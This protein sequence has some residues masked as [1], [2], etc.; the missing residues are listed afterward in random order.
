MLQ[1]RRRVLHRRTHALHAR[2]TA[3]VVCVRVGAPSPRRLAHNVQRQVQPRHGLQEL[4][5]QVH[6]LAE[7]GQRVQR[8]H[9]GEETGFNHQNRADRNQ[10]P[11]FEEQSGALDG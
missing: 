4:G 10:I 11:R 3:K 6:R 8:A 2:E 5:G 9:E 1:L 7:P